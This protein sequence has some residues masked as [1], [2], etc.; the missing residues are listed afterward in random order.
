MTTKSKITKKNPLTFKEWVYELLQDERGHV[1]IKPVIALVGS[2][3]LCGS[4]LANSLTHGTFSPSVDLINAVMVITSIGMG[5]D[6]VDKFSRR[7]RNPATYDSSL[8]E[9]H[10][11]VI[12]DTEE[13]TKEEKEKMDV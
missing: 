12:R 6:S 3:F 9:E 7:S 8:N 10:K 4:M 13:P 5:A 1:S 11:G 2:L